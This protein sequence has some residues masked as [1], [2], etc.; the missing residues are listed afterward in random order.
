MKQWQIKIWNEGKYIDFWAVNHILGGAI[1]AY[2]FIHLDI[3]FLAG[4]AISSATMIV[5]ELYEIKLKIQE[6]VSNRVTD[7][8]TGLLGFIGYYYL[9]ETITIA[10]ISFLIFILLPFILLDIWGFLAYKAE[11]KNR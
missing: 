8:I 11:N 9:N 5:W 4:L 1:L 3:S 7:I 10:F 2:I 6:A